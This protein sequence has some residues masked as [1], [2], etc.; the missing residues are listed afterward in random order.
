MATANTRLTKLDKRNPSKPP[1]GKNRAKKRRKVPMSNAKESAKAR[2]WWMWPFWLLAWPFITVW[3]VLATHFLSYIVGHVKRDEN[4][5]YRIKFVWYG[6]SI[7]MHPMIW[8]S[9]ILWS[10]AAA[11]VAAG[12]L[13]FAWFVCLFLC[14]MTIMYNFDIIRC[15]MLG[16]GVTALAGLAYFATVEWSWNPLQSF[17]KH[18]IWLDAKVTPGF[19][20]ASAYCF[21]AV[22]CAEVI[23]SWLFRRVEIDE[24]Y[25]YEHGFLRGTTREPIFA[26]GL[27]RETKDLLELLILG[28][29]DIQHRTKNGF[30]RFK[31]VPF[32]SLWLGT[33]I[34]S[35]LDYRR[36]GEVALDGGSSA[37]EDQAKIEHAMQD[38]EDD[39]HDD[40][41][42]HDDGDHDDGDHDDGGGMA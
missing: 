18:V 32:A 13:L 14:F 33:A 19:Y 21:T 40:D 15:A 41:G 34:D 30:K 39:G 7:Y 6:D 29:A 11:N 36:K 3:N 24:S 10:L 12:W 37:A 23:W 25:V 28:A 9:L 17:A 5:I 27:K 20:I 42:D 16:V 1:A 26:R 38:L 35:L 4:R 2:P 8:G 31:N 22:I